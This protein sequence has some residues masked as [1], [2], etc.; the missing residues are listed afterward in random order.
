MLQRPQNIE[1]IFNF[2][3][4]LIY[5]DDLSNFLIHIN[6]RNVCLQLFEP[7]R[8]P[9]GLCYDVYDI[10]LSQKSFFLRIHKIFEHVVLK[11]K[12]GNSLDY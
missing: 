12:D 8:T 1:Y 2:Q 6:D 7:L 10:K 5:F 9:C 11:R 3:T 4:I